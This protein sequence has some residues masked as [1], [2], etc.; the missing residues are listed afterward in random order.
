MESESRALFCAV[1]DCAQA[2]RDEPLK[3]ARMR[4]A[5]VLRARS[6]GPHGK[7]GVSDPMRPV[8]ALVDH[9]ARAG[10]E[11]AEERLMLKRAVAMLSTLKAVDWL[12]ATILYNRYLLLH[13]WREIADALGMGMDE[14]RG[15]ETM[16][17]ERMDSEGMGAMLYGQMGVTLAEGEGRDRNRGAN[18][19][20]E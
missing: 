15:R 13:P 7:G 2:L 18:R 17:F 10:A 6:D 12:G 8:D 20:A 14:V 11:M 1:R 9:E 5:C 3:M 16:A 19:N 4:E